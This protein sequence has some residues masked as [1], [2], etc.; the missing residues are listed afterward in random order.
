MNIYQLTVNPKTGGLEAGGCALF[1]Q[2]LVWVMIPDEARIA[3]SYQDR[4]DEL[5]RRCSFD[6]K[7]LS[8]YDLD[9]LFDDI[10]R[11]LWTCSQILYDPAEKRWYL[12]DFPHLQVSG[13]FI[14]R[15]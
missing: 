14:Q 7:R 15:R 6:Y 9:R 3:R 11:D 8:L 5:S 12:E 10:W 4:C 1:P 2:D 13:L